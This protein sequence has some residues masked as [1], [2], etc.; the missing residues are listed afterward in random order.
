MATSY[1]VSNTIVSASGR[2]AYGTLKLA[3]P[4]QLA[5]L[6]IDCEE[7]RGLRAVLVGMLWEMERP[8]SL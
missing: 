7:D 5:E 1:T 2:N 3:G 6:P 8:T 4:V